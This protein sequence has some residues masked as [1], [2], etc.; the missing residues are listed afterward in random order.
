MERD[1]SAAMP[2]TKTGVFSSASKSK[3]RQ[4][5]T[6][7][8][9]SLGPARVKDGPWSN[10]PA[11]AR[12][13][14]LDKRAKILSAIVCLDKA[15]TAYTC[16]TARPQCNTLRSCAERQYMVALLCS[17]VSH[18]QSAWAYELGESTTTKKLSINMAP[19]RHVRHR[20]AWPNGLPSLPLATHTARQ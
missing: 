11:D 20:R 7:P 16:K 10:V 17:A 14:K 3:A 12:L 2:C 15:A 5:K 4:S 1:G 19:W 13:S 18:C 6:C 9:D 8:P